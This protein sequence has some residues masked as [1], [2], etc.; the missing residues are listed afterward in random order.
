MIGS[1]TVPPR[2]RLRSGLVCALVSDIVG[3]GYPPGSVLPTEAELCARFDVSRTVVREAIK[4]LEA[5]GMVTVHQGRGSIVLPESFWA[6][7]DRDIFDARLAGDGGRPALDDLMAVRWALE[8]AM[9]EQAASRMG[10][11]TAEELARLLDAAEGVLD[12]PEQFTELDIR[13]HG[14]L[15][16]ASGNRLAATIV[17]AI[18]GVLR[19][20]RRLA[21]R[22]PGALAKAHDSH[23]QILHHV[24]AGDA[25]A[26][27][28][29]MRSHLEGARELLA[30]GD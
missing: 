8:G 25:A 7:L 12:R 23:Q 28:R 14:L 4:L 15:V 20:S 30:G 9:L 26:A 6:P 21:N 22:E 16:E 17:G 19:A 5:K 18:G 2:G 3:G 11:E 29:V 24:R 13:F 27:Q 10:S 1:L